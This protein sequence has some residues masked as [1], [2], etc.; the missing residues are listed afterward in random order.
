MLG[1]DK[2]LLFCVICMYHVSRIYGKW[3]Y[4]SSLPSLLNHHIIVN[5]YCSIIVHCGNSAILFMRPALRLQSSWCP[6]DQITVTT[7]L[8]LALIC[9]H[10]LNN[11]NFH[12]VILG[13]LPDSL[14]H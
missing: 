12:T 14:S 11:S 10:L 2:H 5:G 8:V 6:K 4:K 9:T 7:T 3:G 1:L 13:W